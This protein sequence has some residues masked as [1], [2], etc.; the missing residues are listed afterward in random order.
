MTIMYTKKF[1]NALIQNDYSSLKTIPKTDLH[2][3]CTLGGSQLDLFSRRINVPNSF[4]NINEFSKWCNDNIDIYFPGAEGKKKRIASSFKQANDDSIWYLSLIIGYKTINKLSEF[5]SFYSTIKNLQKE[6]YTH[7]NFMPELGL[8][9][10]MNILKYEGLVQE[11]ISSGFFYSI[12]ISGIDS[13]INSINDFKSIYR[14]A[15][16]KKLT[17]KAHVGEFTNEDDIIR[18][19]ETLHLKQINH[20]IAASK[21]KKVMNY[22]QRNNITLNICPTSNQYFGLCNKTFDEIKKLLFFGVNITINTDDHLVFNS[23][24]SNEFMKLYEYG[25]ISPFELD[26]I[27]KYSIQIAQEQLKK[28]V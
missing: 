18:Y 2:N 21:S 24:V 28:H 27:R 17:L 6:Y 15:E 26:K 20:G 3:H 8:K 7:G 19:I 23:D 11:A 16:N 9:L 1:I 4:K 10:D 22:L 14:Y 5:E 13:A 25:N 12:D